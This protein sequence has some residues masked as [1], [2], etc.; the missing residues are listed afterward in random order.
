MI[1][2][3]KVRAPIDSS[4]LYRHPQRH[5]QVISRTANASHS[6]TRFLKGY[7]VYLVRFTYRFLLATNNP[8]NAEPNSHAVAGMGTALT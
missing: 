7:A 8:A 4:A 2:I 3:K 1:C 5:S 6:M